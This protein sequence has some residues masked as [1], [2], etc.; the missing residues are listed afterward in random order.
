M[1]EYER[2]LSQKNRFDNRSFGNWANIIPQYHADNLETFLHGLVE[3]GRHVLGN[4]GRNIQDYG[5]DFL[6]LQ[7][8]ILLTSLGQ[9][10]MRDFV[11][12][13]VCQREGSV[14][15]TILWLWILYRLIYEKE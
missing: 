1:D 5:F 8:V 6:M 13:G 4:L 3:V 2:V 7:I 10:E 14:F 12:F 15:L 9:E 11:S